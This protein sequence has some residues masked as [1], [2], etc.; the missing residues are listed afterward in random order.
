MV[1][2][3]FTRSVQYYLAIPLK[4]FKTWKYPLTEKILDPTDSELAIPVVISFEF[5]KRVDEPGITNFRAKAPRDMQFGRLF[6]F[7]INDYNDRHPE[8]MIEVAS[9]DKSAFSWVFFHKAKWFNKTRF[10]DPDESILSNQIKE[11][12]V[13]VCQ[14]VNEP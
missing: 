7:F 3:L 10:I 8:G 14:R 13:V 4:I 12:S 9:P 6:Y 11:N 1:P 2:F 5:Q